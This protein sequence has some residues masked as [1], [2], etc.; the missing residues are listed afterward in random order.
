MYARTVKLDPIVNMN[1]SSVTVRSTRK[2]PTGNGGSLRRMH[3]AR[4]WTE[5]ARS[6]NVTMDAGAQGTTRCDATERSLTHVDHTDTHLH[7]GGEQR[8]VAHNLRLARSADA[9]EA[10][11]EATQR[12]QHLS[13]RAALY[14]KRHRGRDKG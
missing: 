4:S 9:D 6:V 13:W 7:E 12:M 3:S 11:E 2:A 8:P 10:V 1:C 14:R 5:I